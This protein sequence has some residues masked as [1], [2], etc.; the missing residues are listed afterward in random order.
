MMNYRERW[1]ED[2]LLMI[3]RSETQ[4]N[5][6]LDYKESR[7]LDKTESKKRELAKDVSAFANSEGG[8]LIYGIKEDGRLPV[9]FDEGID[10]NE[11]TK[12]WIENVIISTI[13]QRVEGVRITQIP[14]LTTRP[15]RVAYVI[16]VPQARTLAPHQAPDHR[17]Y[18]RYN[19]QSVP[20][21]D[22]EVRD[23]LGRA[24]TPD[25]RCRL[26]LNMQGVYDLRGRYD[27][28]PVIFRDTPPSTRPRCR[29]TSLLRTSPRRPPHT[30]SSP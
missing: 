2:A 25:L 16:E 22:Y 1:D 3:I 13:H 8:T 5:I 30:R 9:E 28:A 17:Y 10:P 18:K 6:A 21:E 12:E 24:T 15:G 23:L 27:T 20:M 29:S 26:L 7:A 19:F 4:E 11:I 14:L